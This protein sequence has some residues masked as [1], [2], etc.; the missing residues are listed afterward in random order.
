MDLSSFVL[1][2][3]VAF[4][5]RCGCMEAKMAAA[6]TMETTLAATVRN[7]SSAPSAG[8]DGDGVERTS[9]P[10][11]TYLLTQ[12]SHA[13]SAGSGMALFE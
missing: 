9:G 10:V 2:Q 6:K 3:Q 4:V 12:L 5:R 13:A 11:L 1:A 8:G 7:A